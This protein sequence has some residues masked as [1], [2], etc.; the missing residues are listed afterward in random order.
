MHI[1]LSEGAPAQRNIEAVAVLHAEGAFPVRCEL[2]TKGKRN[3]VG[4]QKKAEIGVNR[5][6]GSHAT[7]TTP[8]FGFVTY[9]ITEQNLR[10][11]PC[12][13]CQ[14]VQN[15]NVKQVSRS[16]RPTPQNIEHKTPLS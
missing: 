5:F 15:S 7:G 10:E 9:E 6:Y 4:I 1:R 13:A 16:G 12:G 8:I 14:V 3:V 2:V 11:V